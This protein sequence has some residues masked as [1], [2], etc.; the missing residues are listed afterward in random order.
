MSS[1]SLPLVFEKLSK[2]ASAVNQSF[3]SLSGPKPPDLELML[4]TQ[5]GNHEAFEQLFDRYHGIV[6]GIARRVL[7]SPEDVAD[8]VQ[9]AF[10][11]VYHNC[12]S[13]NS[14]KG[15]VRT[16]ICCIAHYRSLRKLRHL[17][18]RGWQSEDLQK[19]S[20]LI[21]LQISPNQWIRSMDFQKCLDATLA[22]LSKKQRQTMVLHF[23]EGRDLDVIA[24]ETG[25]SLANTRHHLYRGLAKLRGEL[26]R[27]RLLAGYAE[28]DAGRNEEEVGS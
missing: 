4:F 21:D 17:R 12:G 20:T 10:L 13:F 6:R 9:E 18:N 22:S 5:Q 7:K 14:S 26:I 3:D 2:K 25:Q 19:A 23:F 1:E 16:W 27:S 28:Y 24:A 8:V 11:D 15:T